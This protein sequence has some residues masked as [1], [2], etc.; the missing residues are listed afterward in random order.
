[1]NE[2]WIEQMRQKMADYQWPAPELSWDELD[3]A[4]AA[5]KARKTR[6][7][8]LRRMAAAAAVLL[9][10]GVGYWGFLQ[11]HGDWNH[12]DWHND[13]SAAE[14]RVPVPVIQDSVPNQN[15]IPTIPQ[16]ST[17]AIL[18]SSAQKPTMTVALENHG[19]WHNDSS[20]AKIR[21]PVPVISVPEISE[22]K[23]QPH[24]VEKKAKSVDYIPSVIYP[25][26]LRH[27]KHLDNRLTAKVYVSSTMTDSRLTE[28][29][30]KQITNTT[31]SSKTV[32]VDPTNPDDPYYSHTQHNH[33]DTTLYTVTIYDTIRTVK[34]LKTNQQIR[35]RQPIHFGL[36]L[37]YRIDNRWSIESGLSFTRLVSD[38]TT[39]TEGQVTV[40]EQRL[41]YIGLPLNIS[42]Q[43]WTNRHF[44][45]YLTTGGT[46]EKCLNTSSW[47]FSLNGAAGAEYKLTD[48]FSL[49]AEPGLGYYFNDGSTTPTIYQDRPLNFN[50]SVGL[51]FNLK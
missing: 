6:L 46:I 49:Y 18:A 22:E 17:P 35:H 13:R 20:E 9:I 45:L 42:C 25:S 27:R 30:I 5:G 23:E 3:R 26:D 24:T 2:E 41:N 11:N 38:I 32:I 44:G 40:K 51:R 7:L 43:M 34:T 21:V 4:L 33:G 16:N 50:L 37:R 12:G 48:V 14:I 8:W 47:Q 19:D 31:I 39:I 29:S 1:M 28:S 15:Q 36:S 10:A